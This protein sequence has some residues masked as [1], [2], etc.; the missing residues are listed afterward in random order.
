MDI[1][2]RVNDEEVAWVLRAATPAISLTSTSA[3]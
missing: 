3:I 1:F 2:E